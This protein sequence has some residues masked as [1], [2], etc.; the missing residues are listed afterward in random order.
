L[1]RSFPINHHY[2]TGWK[3]ELIIDHIESAIYAKCFKGGLV[4]LL[5]IDPGNGKVID[6]YKLENHIFPEKLKVQGGF[7]YYLYKNKDEYYEQN[8]YRQQLK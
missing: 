3:N 8:L 4:H 7:A 2:K 5:K 6:E 1:Q